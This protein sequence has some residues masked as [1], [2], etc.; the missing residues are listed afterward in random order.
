MVQKDTNGSTIIVPLETKKVRFDK[1]IAKAY[2]NGE[3]GG[4]PVF[5]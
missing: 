4:L 1:S 3:Y 2:Q 5:K